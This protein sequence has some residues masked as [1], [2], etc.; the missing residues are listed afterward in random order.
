MVARFIPNAVGNFFTNKVLPA[1]TDL[2]PVIRDDQRV[3]YLRFN[4]RH[5]FR[6]MKAYLYRKSR[7]KRH[8]VR[9]RLRP[10]VSTKVRTRKTKLLEAATRTPK[11]PDES[12]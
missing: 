4:V 5:H 10:Y 12:E 11:T 9:G 3:M 7:S 1:F 2:V 6:N 8:G